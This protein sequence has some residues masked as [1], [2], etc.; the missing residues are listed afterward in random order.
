M[1]S[2]KLIVADEKQ[3]RRSRERQPSKTTISP[4]TT[5]NIFP[6]ESGV[7]ASIVSCGGSMKAIKIGRGERRVVFENTSA[8]WEWLENHSTEPIDKPYWATASAA[9]QSQE[10][11]NDDDAFLFLRQYYK[12]VSGYADDRATTNA[13]F[14]LWKYDG[15]RGFEQ[16]LLRHGLISEDATTAIDGDLICEHVARSKEGKV[17][18]CCVRTYFHQDG[19][20]RCS[21]IEWAV[22]NGIAFNLIQR[23]ASNLR[24]SYEDKHRLADVKPEIILDAIKW[25]NHLV[26]FEK[27]I[28][29]LRLD[30]L[31]SK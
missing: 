9:T 1:E 4:G 11:I 22:M 26:W 20:Y 31:Y 3:D 24:R 23:M 2:E 6:A 27:D 7:S 17:P 25:K 19:I 15:N 5:E 10:S 8:N 28:S 12:Y 21:T 16:H 18:T 13:L 14:Q 30:C 29:M